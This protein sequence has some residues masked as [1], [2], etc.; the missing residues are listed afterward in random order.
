M[1]E[2]PKFV[3]LVFKT[4]WNKRKNNDLQKFQILQTLK[5]QKQILKGYLFLPKE[6]L[7]KWGFRIA[8]AYASLSQSLPDI[9]KK[10]WT[11]KIQIINP[12]F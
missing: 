3:N 7:E 4:N 8:T 11:Q 2:F 1:N 9:S 10:T 5:V 6:F 12:R